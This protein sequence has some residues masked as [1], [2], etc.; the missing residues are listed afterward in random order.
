MTLSDLVT[1]SIS[2]FCSLDKEANSNSKTGHT[3][4]IVQYF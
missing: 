1:L 3:D 4:L 2:S